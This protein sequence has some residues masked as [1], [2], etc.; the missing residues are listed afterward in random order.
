MHSS[1]TQIQ[2]KRIDIGDLIVYTKPTGEVYDVGIVIAKASFGDV[3][4]VE[5]YKEERGCGRYPEDF[6]LDYVQK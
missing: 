6:L 3:Y 1:K 2:Q 5:W 4:D